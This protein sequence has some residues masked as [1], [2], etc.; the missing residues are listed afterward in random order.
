MRYETEDTVHT[1]TRSFTVAPKTL[2]AEDIGEYGPSGIIPN[3]TYDGGTGIDLTGLGVKK[4]ALVGTDENLIISGSA[5]F[6]GANAGDT[7]LV[8]TTNGKLTEIPGV[9][10]K[11]SN[12]QIAAGLTKPFAA[13]ID[14][15]WL[16]FTVDSV[17]KRFGSARQHRRRA[18][19]VHRCGGQ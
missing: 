2:T 4:A 8:F 16:D 6:V 19:D 10:G 12:Y 17:S 5:E 18:R 9:P 13:R 14:Q 7:T 3:K 1:G 11:A 15:R